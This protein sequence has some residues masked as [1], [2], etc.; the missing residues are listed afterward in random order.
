M[1]NGKIARLPA[2]L[3]EEVDRRLNDGQNG[4]EVRGWLNA[5]PGVRAVL[6]TQFGG[7]PVSSQ[8]L[9]YCPATPTPGANLGLRDEAGEGR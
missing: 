7:R 2:V 9:S 5:L 1:R 6:D 3:R 8:N 4:P